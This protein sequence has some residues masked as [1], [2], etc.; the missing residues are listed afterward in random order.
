MGNSGSYDSSAITNYRLFEYTK[1]TLYNNINRFC[2]KSR[3]YHKIRS[4]NM[5]NQNF[6]GKTNFT[7]D[8]VEVNIVEVIK[9][10]FKERYRLHDRSR[11]RYRNDSGRFKRNKE[12]M[13][14]E[15]ERCLTPG[16]TVR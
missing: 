11:S 13:V 15:T 8:R 6:R 9:G 3:S 5:N 10:T 14:L 12:N 2:D 1:R 4:Y 16:I 7:D